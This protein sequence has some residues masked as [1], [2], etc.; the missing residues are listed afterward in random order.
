MIVM[1]KKWKV[2]IIFLAISVLI[3]IAFIIWGLYLMSIDDFGKLN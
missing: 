2:I 1:S 3:L